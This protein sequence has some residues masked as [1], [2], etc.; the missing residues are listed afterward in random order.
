MHPPCRAVLLAE[1]TTCQFKTASSSQHM[2][3]DPD[4]LQITTCV[5]NFCTTL[6]PPTCQWNEDS[7]KSYHVLAMACLWLWSN[8]L[9]C[10]CR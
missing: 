7:G 10:L 3:Y 9:Y 5:Q 8:L 1:P 2:T 6:S 4:A